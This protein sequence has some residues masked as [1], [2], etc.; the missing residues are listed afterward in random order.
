MLKRAG[1]FLAWH[2]YR[3]DDG[4]SR[5]ETTGLSRA[6]IFGT[7]AFVDHRIALIGTCT[8]AWIWRARG[9]VERCTTRDIAGEWSTTDLFPHASG[10]RWSCGCRDRR[11]R[12]ADAWQ[13][14][15]AVDVASLN[16]LCSARTCTRDLLPRHAVFGLATRHKRQCE[17]QCERNVVHGAWLAR[18]HGGYE[19]ALKARCFRRLRR[20]LR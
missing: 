17:C 18:M 11:W 1:T 7:I 6:A 15:C 4:F 19:V 14:P 20:C 2:A 10:R 16:A 13:V 12:C 3:A 5:N 8:L 9:R